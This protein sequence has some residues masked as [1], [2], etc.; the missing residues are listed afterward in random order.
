M[1]QSA[2]SRPLKKRP[3]MKSSLALVVPTARVTSIAA[4]ESGTKPMFTKEKAHLLVSETIWKSQGEREGDAGAGDGALDPGDNGL[5]YV[6]QAQV[7]LRADAADLARAAHAVVYPL[8]HGV[9]V[10]AGAE[11]PAG[12]AD[13]HGANLVVIVGEVKALAQLA[14]GVDG[15][16][17]C[18]WRGCSALSRQHRLFSRISRSEIP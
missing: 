15:L 13:N 11:V 16:S 10:A 18:A 3:D 17:D 5:L 6:E 7:G 8:L 12:A 14:V 1:P 2:A 9:E 4:P